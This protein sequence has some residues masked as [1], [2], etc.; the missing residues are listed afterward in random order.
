MFDETFLERLQVF[1]LVLELAA[2]RK[3]FAGYGY[4]SLCDNR[5]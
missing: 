1:G 4:L 3:P 2:V 5:G